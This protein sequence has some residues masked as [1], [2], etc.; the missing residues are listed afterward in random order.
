MYICMKIVIRKL[1][2]PV[3]KIDTATQH[4]CSNSSNPETSRRA[5]SVGAIHFSCCIKQ[6]MPTR[7]RSSRWSSERGVHP[8]T[9][10]RRRLI[11]RGPISPGGIKIRGH[12]L[13]LPLMAPAGS[14]HLNQ[15]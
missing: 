7:S 10:G 4:T 13:L 2:N 14:L 9:H 11:S 15:Q 1:V 5:S 3:P 12:F 8:P 6:T